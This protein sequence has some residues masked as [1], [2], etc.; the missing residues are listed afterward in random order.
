MMKMT[1]YR[2]YLLACA[3]LCFWGCLSEFPDYVPPIERDIDST[4]L[5]SI[6]GGADAAEPPCGH[7]NNTGLVMTTLRERRMRAVCVSFRKRRLLCT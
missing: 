7:A 5:N 1:I 6:D 4:L 2:V 3:L